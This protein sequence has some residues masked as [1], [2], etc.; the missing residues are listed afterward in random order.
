MT[1]KPRNISATKGKNKLF[2][3]IFSAS[4]YLKALEGKH[5]SCLIDHIISSLGFS[6]P[7]LW[8]FVSELFEKIGLEEKR[9]M[10]IKSI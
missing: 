1:S 10:Q 2:N 9:S 3:K 8:V 5:T 4:R 7:I 6:C